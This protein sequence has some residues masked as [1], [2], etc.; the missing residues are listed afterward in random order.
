MKRH[1]SLQRLSRDHHHALV[2]AKRLLDLSDDADALTLEAAGAHVLERWRAEVG[3]HFAAEEECLLPVFGRH[4]GAR[5]PEIIE[6]L[7]QH[8]ELRGL[9][10]AVAADG[11][12]GTAPALETLRA[13]GE[14]L[15][16]HVRY[17]EGVLFP[18][19]EAAL[20][21]PALARLIALLGE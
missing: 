4:A 3:P 14:G 10:D 18:A 17:E 12:A 11:A 1:P 15:R 5:H 21:A 7:C 20:D 9:A 6:T 16:A 13:L 8:V 2:L 19:V